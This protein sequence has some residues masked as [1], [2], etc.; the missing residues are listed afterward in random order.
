MSAGCFSW[1]RLRTQ[2]DAKKQT[3]ETKLPDVSTNSLCATSLTH[4]FVQ[5]LPENLPPIVPATSA[6]KQFMGLKSDEVRGVNSYPANSLTGIWIQKRSE[7]SRT[8]V[9]TTAEYAMATV[10]EVLNLSQSVARVMPVPFLQDVIGVALNIIQICEV[11][12]IP[13]WIL[14]NN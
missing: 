1:C 12:S 13:P 2:W 10:K 3:T 5:K 11:R 14:Q 4:I 8:G 6:E 9:P 7:N